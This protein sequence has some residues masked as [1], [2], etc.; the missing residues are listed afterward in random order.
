M[1]ELAID[2]AAMLVAARRAAEALL[3]YQRAD[4]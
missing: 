1:D 3:R 4:G 2:R